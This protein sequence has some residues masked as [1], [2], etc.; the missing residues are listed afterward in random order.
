MRDDRGA[1]ANRIAPAGE[2]G[3][4]RRLGLSLCVLGL[5][6]GC[7]TSPTSDPSAG[8]AA[9]PPEPAA[10][11][12]SEP[13]PRPEIPSGWPPG[14]RIVMHV[15][16]SLDRSYVVAC[17]MP[18]PAL[19]YLMRGHQV[20]IIVDQDAV[21]AFRRDAAGK[22]PLDRLELLRDDTDELAHFVGLPR[23]GLPEDFGGLYRLLAGRGIRLVANGDALRSLGIRPEEM[24]PALTVVSGDEVR[25]LTSDLD[26]LL[27]YDEIGPMHSIFRHRPH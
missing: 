1:P 18:V 20:T 7:A 17:E 4:V 16:P 22:T 25:R 23:A 3:S 5:V 10:L 14:K 19:T 27:P 15:T 12:S 2:R 8:S 26:A 24:D 11:V 6:A 9:T 21:T 13:R